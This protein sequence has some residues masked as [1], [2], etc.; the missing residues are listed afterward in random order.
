M[1]ACIHI[2]YTCC[3]H[4]ITCNSMS[5]ATCLKQL[6]KFEL[7]VLLTTKNQLQMSQKLVFLLE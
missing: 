2:V 6:H 4:T 3:V 7:H 5:C 1:N